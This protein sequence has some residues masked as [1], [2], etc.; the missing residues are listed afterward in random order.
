VDTLWLDAGGR[1]V[2][3]VVGWASRT[4]AYGRLL[5]RRP[6][7]PHAPAVAPTLC[8]G[9]AP[10]FPAADGHPSER[11]PSAPPPL[12]PTRRATTV[13]GRGGRWVCRRRSAAPR[14]GRGGGAGGRPPARRR[15]GE[16]SDGS[17]GRPSAGG[18]GGGGASRQRPPRFRRS[19]A[20]LRRR[21]RDAASA[22]KAPASAGLSR[23]SSSDA[24]WRAATTAP[25][26]SGERPR[27]GCRGPHLLVTLFVG[28]S[29]D[30]TPVNKNP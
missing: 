13:A 6:S 27:R 18:T 3:E 1:A 8:T 15:D 11:R 28:G 24:A 2:L 14:D 9:G 5:A 19:A 26:S 22:L 30:P 12:P 17:G 10:A 23:G 25:S 7:P 20:A 4:G 21:H 16:G 29:N